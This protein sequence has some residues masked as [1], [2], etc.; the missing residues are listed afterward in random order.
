[1]AGK[2]NTTR[3]EWL[4]SQYHGLV[5]RLEVQDVELKRISEQLAKG[6]ESTAGHHSKIIRAL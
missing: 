1:M 6:G 4:E 2:D 5:A 3:I